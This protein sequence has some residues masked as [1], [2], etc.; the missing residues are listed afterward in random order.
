QMAS[1]ATANSP[2]PTAEDDERPPAPPLRMASFG[3]DVARAQPPLRPPDKPLP[4]PPA[5]TGRRRQKKKSPKSPP[6]QP[7]PAAADSGLSPTDKPS[8]SS[9]RNFK[10]TMHVTFDQDRREFRGMPEQWARLLSAANIT[11]QEQ[12]QNPQALIEALRFLD[13]KPAAG[14]SDKFLRPRPPPPAPPP[15]PPPQPAPL[16]PRPQSPGGVAKGDRVAPAPEAP[17]AI[18]QQQRRRKA[19]TDAEVLE[20]LRSVVSGGQPAGRFERLEQIGHGASGVVHAGL[21]LRTGSQVAIK[22][23]LIAKQPKKEL[24]VNEIVVMKETRH[25]NIVNFLDSF[26]V[27]D[28][29]WVV[30][31]YLGGGSLTDVVTET[32]MDEDQ[33]GAVCREVLGALHFL[34]ENRVIHRDIKSDNVLLGVDGS[35]KLTD[36]GFCAQLE[37]G[38]S[39]QRHTMVGTP[40]WMAP[41]LVT[42]KSYGPKVD[43]WALGIMAIEMVDGEPPYLNEN[44][45]RALYLIAANGRPLARDRHRVSG[46]LSEFTDSCL[47]VDAELRPSA[48]DLLRHPLVAEAPPVAC[49]VP[50]IVA[51]KGRS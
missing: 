3:G 27:G 20:R 28:E 36:F 15:P 37:S 46:R 34:H 32:C 39:G 17:P 33:I 48:G 13:A 31:E 7:P 43:V 16:L 10:H 41:E 19:A 11:R 2:P 47:E 14:C 6:P 51:A 24:I 12:Q 25:A 8:I 35:V 38:G 26:L 4:N 50:L 9:P 42:R 18:R 5:P 1:A 40:Y 30:M 29:L 44:P 23:M 21:D 45:L 49:L 22:Q